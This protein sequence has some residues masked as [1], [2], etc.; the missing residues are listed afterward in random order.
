[1]KINKQNKTKKNFNNDC[2][3]IAVRVPSRENYAYSPKMAM[4]KFAEDFYSCRSAGILSSSEK[5]VLHEV[6]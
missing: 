1:M 2:T 3:Q 4:I 5:S 6:E